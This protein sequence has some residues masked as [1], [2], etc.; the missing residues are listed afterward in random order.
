MASLFTQTR[1]HIAAALREK[2]DAGVVKLRDHP[3]NV[4]SVL[5]GLGD[6]FTMQL[7]SDPDWD[8]DAAFELGIRTARFLLGADD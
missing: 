4:A 1:D 5:L 2:H 3:E 7:I 8:S 6:G